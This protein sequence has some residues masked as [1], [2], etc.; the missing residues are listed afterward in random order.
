MIKITFLGTCSG[1]EPFAGMHHCSL[2]M[3]I[4][5]ANYWFD[6]GECCAYTAHTLGIDIMKTKALFISHPHIDH[7]GGLPHLLFCIGKLIAKEK[8]S[9][10]YNNTL[11]TF[12]SDTSVL[13]A[14]N[15]MRKGEY[16]FNIVSHEL[17]EG[18]I[19]EDEN[20]RISAVRNTHM[21]KADKTVD[22]RAFSFLIEAEGKRIVY[23]G[24]VGKP[25]ELDTLI[26]DGVDYLIHETGH[27][28]VK[29]VCEYAISR[30]VK[31][32]RFNHH[33]RE[34]INDREAA[35]RLTKE[36]EQNAEKP[37]S[38]VICHDGMSETLG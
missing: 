17:D 5:G 30:N 18:V 6:A 11:E 13:E 9:L 16:K 7:I 10:E 28:S 3:E 25:S 15:M 8:R 27:H 2:I 19:F 22:P 1:T 21:K 31:A 37:I 24:D 12:M 4:G 26:G 14:V 36:Y 33:G 34:I 32:L 23:S 35:K 38:I 20:V 29:D